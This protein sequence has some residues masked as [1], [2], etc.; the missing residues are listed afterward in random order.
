MSSDCSIS[1]TWGDGPHT[2]RL[3]IKQQEELQ[4]K[5]DAGPEMLFARVAA[6]LPNVLDLRETIRLGLVGGGMEPPAAVKLVERYV[7]DCP[8]K[9]NHIAARAILEACIVGVPDDPVGKSAAG[10][11]E[12]RAPVEKTAA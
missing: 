12:A 2:F 8:R 7:D 1:F 4:E 3:G 11:A 6:G 10:E 9:P 5:C